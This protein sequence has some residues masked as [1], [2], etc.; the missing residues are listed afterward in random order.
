MVSRDDL[1]KLNIPRLS[2]A[3][4]SWDD[5]GL[6]S[7]LGRDEDVDRPA[8]SPSKRP[9]T[10]ETIRPTFPTP[11]DTTRTLENWSSVQ[12][13]AGNDAFDEIFQL[14]ANLS[15]FTSYPQWTETGFNTSAESSYQ[16]FNTSLGDELAFSN[17][18]Y[19]TIPENLGPTP[20]ADGTTEL[21]AWTQSQ[22]S[23]LFDWSAQWPVVEPFETGNFDDIGSQ[24]VHQEPI[25]LT[26]TSLPHDASP[27]QPQGTRTQPIWI[28]DET[29]SF[30]PKA[31]Q[32]DERDPM[33]QTTQSYDQSSRIRTVA[34]R[35]STTPPSWERQEAQLPSPTE[36]PE[37]PYDTC[38]G[39][40]SNLKHFIEA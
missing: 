39:S 17:T 22:P 10:P 4:R 5:D 9:C 18:Q 13:N 30:M 25:S 29:D 24:V 20:P 27:P 32:E 28:Q 33:A 15:A 3:K 37:L 21:T 14:G 23:Q 2:V 8:R 12:N 35:M 40:V 36:S 19:P 38:F 26:S 16:M 34:D 7:D 11:T 31:I 1:K 6:E